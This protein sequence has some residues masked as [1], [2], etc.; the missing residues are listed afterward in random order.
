MKEKIQQLHQALS[1]AATAQQNQQRFTAA[2]RKFM[3]MKYLTPTML[4]E[5]IDHI[6]IHETEG[7]GKNRSQ[8]IEI[9]YRFVGY[10]DIPWEG[11]TYCEHIRQGV[12][13][14]FITKVKTAG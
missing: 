14:E 11:S 13:Q 5:L 10:L 1:E 6:V 8:Q 2:V 9:Y 4:H 12:E 7:S 3:E